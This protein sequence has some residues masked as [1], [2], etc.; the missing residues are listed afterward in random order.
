MKI[1]KESDVF[2]ETDTKKWNIKIKDTYNAESN[3][4][5]S[6]CLLYILVGEYKVIIIK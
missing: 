4:Y 6:N 2:K 5:S 1:M 3:N